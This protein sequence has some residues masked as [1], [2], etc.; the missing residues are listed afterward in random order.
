M[1]RLLVAVLPRAR[2]GEH[3][4][5]RR[6]VHR[7]LLRQVLVQPQRVVRVVQPERRIHNRQNHL[8]LRAARHARHKV[9]PRNR[10]QLPRR[11]RRH[12]LAAEARA[13][14]ERRAAIQRARQHG[15]PRRALQQLSL[16]QVPRQS[17][18]GKEVEAQRADDRDHV[19]YVRR[20]LCIA[21]H[22]GQPVDR[23][24]NLYI[25]QAWVGRVAWYQRPIR[26]GQVELHLHRH[27][28]VRRVGADVEAAHIRLAPAIDAVGRRCYLAA[29]ARDVRQQQT[30]PQYVVPF[31]VDL[32]PTHRVVLPVARHRLDVFHVAA[33]ARYLHRQVEVPPRVR[34]NPAV[35]AGVA[36]AR[37]N[38]RGHDPAQLVQPRHSRTERQRLKYVACIVVER[39]HRRTAQRIRHAH[40]GHPAAHPQM[41]QRLARGNREP[42]RRCVVVGQQRLLRRRY[43]RARIVGDRVRLGRVV[44]R[45]PRENFHAHRDRLVAQIRLIEP[46]AHVAGQV[47][48][49]RR[50]R[51]RL[52]QPQK[53]VG[54]V[55]QPHKRPRQ[56]ADPAV[57]P[58]RV[59]ALLLQ[60][61]QQ[62]YRSI[63][64]ILPRLGIV[65][66]LQHFEVTQLV[67]P[68]HRHLP[69]LAA[70]H[71]ALFQQQLT[72]DHLVPRDR[73]ARELDPRDIELLALVDID[74][75]VHQLLRLIDP[76]LY[77][78]HHSDVAL[79]AI[80][81][82]QVLQSLAERRRREPFAVLLCELCTQ[83]LVVG[84]H[85]VARKVDP[86]QP[87]AF[88]LFHRHQDVD[89]LARRRP[90]R[91]PV[92]PALVAH[93]RLRV[94]RLR[95]EVAV[96]LV[97]LAHPLRV[98]V[99]FARVE[100][101][102]QQILQ[103][104]RVRHADRPCI[105]HRAAQ[106]AA[107]QVV[108]AVEGDLPH[109]H[110]RPFLDAERDPHRRRRNRLHLGPDRRKLVSMLAQQV[111]Q[112]VLG[113]LHPCRIVLA[114]HRQSDLGLLI[115]FL[116]VGLRYRV[117]PL[118]IDRADGRLLPHIDHQLHA[119]RCVRPLNLDL[120]EV[121]RVPQRVEVPLHRRRVIRI[122]LVARHPRQY[123][124]LGNP[125]VA[126]RLRLAQHLCPARFRRAL[127]NRGR[128]CIL[129]PHGS[130]GHKNHRRRHPCGHHD[131]SNAGVE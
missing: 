28:R 7:Q 82:A 112:N 102:G 15:C 97:R 2:V 114:L 92:Q 17:E 52:A 90:Q 22:R 30:H 8:E 108:V 60:L 113:P 87:V 1:Q 56:S 105:H 72:P 31:P 110:R 57:H 125:A 84:E 65:I 79:A 109:L 121:A 88:S 25:A 71:L 124:V 122:A 24:R 33:S 68:Q 34:P 86:A 9:G 127:R 27:K 50:R 12:R 40:P 94:G 5:E 48:D 67:Q 49:V 83:R 47:A 55:V 58:N 36:E 54:L 116:H 11:K 118:V 101:P 78:R 19:L 45:L 131:N 100:R 70:V 75:H 53:V 69:A 35:Q 111:L 107:A 29:K 38:R 80:R 104:D 3:R 41:L 74:V 59:L 42:I 21:A 117:H 130:R 44:V 106:F 20:Q 37:C 93:M 64:L 43:I 73:I 63:V 123:R 32:Q 26:V 14:D 81:L 126:D 4:A 13:V 91:E 95:L 51:Q 39:S 66:H 62:V 120:L 10:V 129:R 6:I 16:L 77:I 128:A 18:V 103:H 85:L 119:R 98:L 76:R 61:Q 23:Q 96:V 115:P 89:A 46:E 99:Q